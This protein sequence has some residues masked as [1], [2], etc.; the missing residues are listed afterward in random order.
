M[1]LLDTNVLIDAFDPA[2]P[3]HGWAA[4]LLRNGL[5]GNGVAINLVILAEICVGD[6]SP[7]TPSRRASKLSASAFSTS[8]RPLRSDVP[9]PMPPTSITG[10]NNPRPRPQRHRFPI[11]SSARMPPS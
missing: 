4:A 6:R 8:P 10:G 2:A 9:K 11:S 5:L 3:T 7:P 1:I